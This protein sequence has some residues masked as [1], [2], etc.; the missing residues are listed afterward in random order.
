MERWYIWLSI[1]AFIYMWRDTMR[2]ISKLRKITPKSSNAYGEIEYLWFRAL[3]TTLSLWILC[4]MIPSLLIA[5][6]TSILID[7]SEYFDLVADWF[8]LIGIYL[9]GVFATYKYDLWRK[10]NLPKD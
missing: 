9:S 4:V 1:P 8:M 7:Y 5:I 6:I 3:G 2:C 10:K